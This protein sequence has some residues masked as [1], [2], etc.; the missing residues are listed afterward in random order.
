[1][2][3]Y[4]NY[5]IG[6]RTKENK[7][8]PLGPF[9]A[10]GDLRSVMSI[11]RSYASDLHES[12]DYVSDDQ[13]SDEL[14]KEFQYENFKGELELDRIKYLQVKDLPKEDFVKRGYFRITDVEEYLKEGWTEGLEYDFM[15]P[16]AY[17]FR[18]DNELKFGRPVSTKDEEGNDLPAKSCADYM[19]F[20]YPDYSCK[21]YECMMLRRVANMLDYG[22]MPKESVLVVLETEG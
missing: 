1:M 16:E 14:R 17:A 18:R 8:Y 21:G 6:Y 2:S 5:F 22:D 7:I 9:D 20:A 15:T 12:F 3:Y 10:F 4:Y 13:V 11:S 19:Y